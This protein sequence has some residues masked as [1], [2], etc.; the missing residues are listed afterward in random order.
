MK[1]AIKEITS[2]GNYTRDSTNFLYLNTHW[3]LIT[4]S[5]WWPNKQDNDVSLDML[6]YW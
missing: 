2:Y 6:V 1:S 3:N 5:Y 4:L